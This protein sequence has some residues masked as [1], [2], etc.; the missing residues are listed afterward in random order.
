MVWLPHAIP[1]PAA[2]SHTTPNSEL[3]E[4]LSLI[5]IVHVIPSGEVAT[6]H[7]PTNDTATNRLF[8][9]DHTT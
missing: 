8:V 5:R 9:P 2:S 7:A 1:R 6:R 3:L 4:V